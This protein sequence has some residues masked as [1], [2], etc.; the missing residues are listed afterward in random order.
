MNNNLL[1]V[2]L[3]VANGA[4]TYK[5]VSGV[6]G[7]SSI[8][9]TTYWIIKAKELGLLEEKGNAIYRGQC[10][11]VWHDNGTVRVGRAEVVE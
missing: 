9:F 11:A 8:P 3:A 6:C 5:E 7:F 4:R 2:V 1:A 10:L